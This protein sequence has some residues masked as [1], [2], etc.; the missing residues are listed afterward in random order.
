MITSATIIITGAYKLL[1]V[2]GQY[3]QTCP[4]ALL[5]EGFRRLQMMMG[6][7]ALQPLTIPVVAREVFPL[8]TG[9]GGTGNPYTV[10]AGGDLNTMRPIELEGAGLLLNASIP[11]VEIPRA[12]YTDDTYEALQIKDLTNSLFTGVYYNATFPLGSLSLWP[13]P[14]NNINSLV[15]Y[16]NQQLGQFASPSAQYIFPEGADEPV[17][18]NLAVKLSDSSSVPVERLAN[19]RDVA[20]TSLGIF[21]RSNHKLVDMPIDPAFTHSKRGGYNINTGTGGGN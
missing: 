8:V 6:Q 11:P 14:D 13:V 15:I 7:W 5:S 9:K 20:K 3:E 1:Q 21:K 18:Y 12:L 10:G 17:E 2:I 19:I 4:P 16:R